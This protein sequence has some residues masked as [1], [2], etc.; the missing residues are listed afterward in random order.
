MEKGKGGGMGEVGMVKGSRGGK[1]KSAA[2]V[3]GG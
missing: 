3:D 1:A 2:A